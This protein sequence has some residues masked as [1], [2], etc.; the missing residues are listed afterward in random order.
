MGIILSCNKNKPKCDHVTDIIPNIHYDKNTITNISLKAIVGH[1]LCKINIESPDDKRIT[2]EI[3]KDLYLKDQPVIVNRVKSLSH[4]AM[5]I[6]VEELYAKIVV[7]HFNI[8]DINYI[9]SYIKNTYLENDKNYNIQVIPEFMYWNRFKNEMDKVNN[10]ILNSILKF[11]LQAPRKMI[12]D[13]MYFFISVKDLFKNVFKNAISKQI[14]DSNTKIQMEAQYLRLHNDMFNLITEKLTNM[15]QLSERLVC[16]ENKGKLE[17]YQRQL[18][19]KYQLIIE[20]ELVRY[21]FRSYVRNCEMKIDGP[22][23]FRIGNYDVNM[24]T[25]DNC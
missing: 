15:G 12:V 24:E 10:N 3:W 2:N 25:C 1:I 14:L 17:Y 11:S 5:N 6:L 7:Q 9:V 22:F 4:F 21:T 20:N 23:I 8:N 19:Y 13:N 18:H 16:E